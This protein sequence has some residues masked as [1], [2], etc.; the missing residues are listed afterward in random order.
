[1]KKVA[2]F[3]DWDNLRKIIQ[4]I[5]NQSKNSENKITKLDFNNSSHISKLFSKYLQDDEIFYRI[6]FYTAKPLK[7]EEIK[8]QLNSEDDKNNYQRY[9]DRQS[10]QNKIYNIATSFLEDI[11]KENFIALRTGKM[12]VR[13]IVSGGRDQ[14]LFKN[15]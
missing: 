4:K 7:D 9:L 14:I 2:F 10:K 1:M 15:K 5:K 6:F 13:G 12:Q 8:K 3:V 11:V